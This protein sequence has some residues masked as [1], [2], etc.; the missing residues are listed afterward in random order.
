MLKLLMKHGVWQL[1]YLYDKT[2]F[3]IRS[4]SKII[5]YVGT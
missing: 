1:R 2:I 5:K 4:R 3:A